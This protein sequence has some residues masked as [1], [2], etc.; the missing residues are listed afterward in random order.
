MKKFF[1]KWLINTVALYVAVAFVPGIHAQT[2]NWLSFIWLAAI[3]GL[4]NSLLRPILKVLSCPLILLTFGLFT[5]IINTAMFSL[6]GQLGSSFGVGFT[7][8]NFMAAF[9]GAIVVSLVGMVLNGVLRE[10]KQQEE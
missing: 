10:E 1:L 8:E 4:L 2:N 5:L 6:A 3:F 7:V 9:W